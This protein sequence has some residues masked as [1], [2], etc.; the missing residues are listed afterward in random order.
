MMGRQVC[1]RFRPLRLKSNIGFG[2]DVATLDD[3][4]N[5]ELVEMSWGFRTPAVSKKTGKPIKPNA[6]NNARDDKLLISGLW[7]ASFIK[8]RCLM[9]VSSLNETKGQQPATDY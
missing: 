9:P 3:A 1:S 7:K 6:W 2:A 5:R 4:G 8:R